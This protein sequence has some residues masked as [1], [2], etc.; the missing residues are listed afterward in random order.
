MAQKKHKVSAGDP[1]SSKKILQKCSCPA[2]LSK[3]PVIIE[4]LSPLV[5]YLHA[6]PQQEI[7]NNSSTSKYKS[8]TTP[9]VH[10]VETAVNT[11]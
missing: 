11:P 5:F 2:V 6:T 8:K 9:I 4:T 3:H 1:E 10:I 7:P